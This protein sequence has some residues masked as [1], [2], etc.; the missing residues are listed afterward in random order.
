M[1]STLL[2]NQLYIIKRIDLKAD[3]IINSIILLVR[4]TNKNL[5]NSGMKPKIKN[6]WTRDE[7]K[8][9]SKL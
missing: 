4:H 6:L 7:M 8:N 3:P 1:C 5:S 9:T 2:M